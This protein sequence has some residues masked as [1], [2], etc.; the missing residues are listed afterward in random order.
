M[1]KLKVPVDVLYEKCRK[2][3]NHEIRIESREEAREIML[4]TTEKHRNDFVKYH[5][6][7]MGNI[8]CMVLDAAKQ[9]LV[10]E[11]KLV[12]KPEDSFGHPL[13]FE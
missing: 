10:K 13:T 4:L 1:A 2:V 6:Q 12:L 5:Q 3:I 8:C 9:D 7:D 11:G